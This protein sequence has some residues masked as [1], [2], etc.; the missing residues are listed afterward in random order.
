MVRSGLVWCVGLS[1]IAACTLVALPASPLNS[2]S[3]TR[4][5]VVVPAAVTATAHVPTPASSAEP[6][7]IAPTPTTESKTAVPYQVDSWASLSPNGQWIA[8]VVIMFPQAGAD[9]RYYT[10]LK[11]IKTDQS[12]AWTVVDEWLNWG[13]GYTTPSVV[14]WSQDGR[15]VYLQDT[16]TADGCQPFPFPSHIRRVDLATGEVTTITPQ[17][18]TVLAFSNDDTRL[19]LATNAGRLQVVEVSAGEAFE[20]DLELP[21]DSGVADIAWSPDHRELLLTLIRVEDAC[22]LS[23]D[24]RKSFVR[25]DL[26]ALDQAVLLQDDR[27]GLRVVEWSDPGQILLRDAMDHL[28]RL[29]IKTG[30]LI[31]LP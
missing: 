29:D 9:D 28:W 12:L 7:G 19:A 26:E 4:T 20:I 5:P 21:A 10:Q 17:E 15:Y 24:V 6:G 22:N 14:R 11:L 27:R 25:V 13:L 8:V 18:G 23:D 16:A 31:P 1:L 3:A 2:S 30:L